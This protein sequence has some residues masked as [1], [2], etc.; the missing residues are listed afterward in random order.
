MHRSWM[1]NNPSDHFHT[2][3]D[4]GDWN[5]MDKMGHWLMSYN[6]SRWVYGGAR[7]TGLNHRAA[8]WLGFA[9][10]QLIQTSFEIF[11]GF[12][13]QAGLIERG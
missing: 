11:D 8:A 3:N 6:E 4:F 2:I 13:D 10:G 7:W 1:A 12:S 5:Q 9:G